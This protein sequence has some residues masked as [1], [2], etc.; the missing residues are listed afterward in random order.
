MPDDE[1]LAVRFEMRSS[2]K[3]IERLDEWRGKQRP[4]PSRAEAIRTLV[5]TALDKSDA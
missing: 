3:W 1:P 5:A 2:Q 4:I